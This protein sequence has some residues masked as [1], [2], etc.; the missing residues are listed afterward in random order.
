[1]VIVDTLGVTLTWT[2]HSPQ[3]STSPHRRL[4]HFAEASS[5]MGLVNQALVNWDE[6]G[7]AP[8]NLILGIQYLQWACEPVR[9]DKFETPNQPK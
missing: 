7:G 9:M 2:Q 3:K 4:R 5:D 8:A 6:R 1:M